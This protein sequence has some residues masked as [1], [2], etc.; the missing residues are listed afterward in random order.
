MRVLWSD[1]PILLFTKVCHRMKLMFY[2]RVGTELQEFPGAVWLKSV[3]CHYDCEVYSS[4]NILISFLNICKL[5]FFS[6][7][8]PAWRFYSRLWF[9]FVSK[10][11][12]RIFDYI[13]QGNLK[14]INSINDF[15]KKIFF[16]AC[17]FL[18]SFECIYFKL[19]FILNVY[20]FF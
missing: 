14:K 11:W 15:L 18:W 5:L 13:T 9:G 17:E 3:I 12:K 10:F 20:V 1:T 6:N 19:D 8:A 7:Q 4:Q 16:T 2:E